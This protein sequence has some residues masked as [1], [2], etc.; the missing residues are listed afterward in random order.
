MEKHK[1]T[2]IAVLLAVALLI[3]HRQYS[4]RADDSQSYDKVHAFYYPWYGNPQTDKFYYHW[5]HQQFVKEGEPKNYPGGDDVAASFYP[6]LG[7]YSSKSDQ[8]LDAHML[9][10]GRAKVGTI[11]TSWWG[12]DSYTD[13]AV[14][15][16]LD[17]AARHNI[18]VCFHIEP[19]P[20]RNAQTTRDAIVYIIDKYGSHSAFYRYGKDKPLPMFYVYD[21]YLTPAEQWKIILSPD[22]PQTIRNTKY[23]SVVIGLWV[24]EHEQDFMTEGNFDGFYTYFA[25][26]GFTYGSTINKWPGLAEWA[27]QNDK[28]FI[29]SVG[30]GYIDLRIRPWNDV[31]TRDRQNGTYYDREFAA[32]I[33]VRPTIISITSFNEWHEGTQIE[34]AVPKQIPDFKYLDYMPH[35]PEYYL[36]RTRY[37]VERY[38]EYSATQSTKYMIVVTGSEL[39]SGAYPDGHTYFLTRTLRPL[40]LEC[41]GS[42]SVDDKQ[43][44]LKE[45]LRY[46]TD[47]ADLVI[48]T[49][50]LGP[51]DNDITREALSDFT[52]ITLKEHPDVLQEMA[53]RFHVPPDQLRANLRRQTQVPTE[54]TYFR[55]T[56]GTAV[57][58]AFEPAE[59]I[60]VALPGPP[61]ELQAMV[62]NELVPYLSRRFGTRLPGCSL[63]LRFVGLGQSQIDQSLEDNVPLAP[64]ITVSSQ[65]EG[66]RVDFT[67]SLPEDTPQDRARLLDLKQKIMKYLGEYVYADDETSLEE[68]VLKLLKARGERLALAE[69]GSS[70]ALAAALS[71]ADGDGQVLA[72]AYVA[73]TVEKLCHLLGVDNDDPTGGTSG[74]QKIKRLAAA[75]ADATASQWAIAVGEVRR[76]Q[77]GSGYVEVAFKLPDGS[78]D[79]RQVR[80][81]GTGELAR[82]RLST[83]LLD[84]LRRRL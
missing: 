82:L 2:R 18:K 63:T 25:T 61:R 50:G 29:P 27:Q 24:K 12:K 21:S 51:T 8:D 4:V 22:G 76:D 39:L 58:L 32:A 26:D 45:A 72:G 80:L 49:G 35:E 17:A 65:F 57:G 44:D 74:E 62:R 7:C 20:G 66:S 34:L 60:I 6:K 31:N 59:D 1:K 11:C 37:W 54:G 10:L 75:A 13:K 70:G 68:H 79:T 67:F 47:K 5:S 30:P 83:Q 46:T 43:A 48:V 36:D 84:Q 9:M 53:R 42:M 23:D 78:L 33:A 56:E 16:L 77:N 64:D 38:V 28:L 73:P 19:F 41:I 15:R 81:S 3:C 40:G 71:S 55:N 14:P 69:V 52:G